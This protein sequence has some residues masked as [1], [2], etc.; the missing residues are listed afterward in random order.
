MS[1]IRI[2]TDSTA[3]LS[4]DLQKQFSI[5]VVPLKVI[6]GDESYLDG[7]TMSSDQFYTKL[8]QVTY[9]PTTSQPS[10]IDFANTYRKIAEETPDAQ[11]ISIHL[12]STL[13]GTYQ[14]A[15]L[16]KSMLENKINITVIDSL[17]VSYGLG[18]NVLAAAKAVLAGKSYEECVA[19]A[20]N[21][22]GQQRIYFMVDTLEYL[23]KGGRI[24]KAAALIGSLLNIKPVLTV[25]PSGEVESVDKIRGMKKAQ[26]R[27]VELL[28]QE[29]GSDLIDLSVLHGAA[30]QEA[31]VWGEQVKPQFNVREWSVE[32]VGP[33]LGVHTGPGTL[34][35]I[36]TR[37]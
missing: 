17:S 25:T 33:V 10:P 23:Q 37:A 16:A 8:Q 36:A 7:K 9:L 12:S 5:E 29:Y 19:V 34:A 26:A 18:Y 21:K 4:D 14:S 22:V 35:L 30:E 27:I 20:K 3:D 11:I 13:S 28:K 2:V 6:F 31:L 15:M 24:G 1:Q 32:Q